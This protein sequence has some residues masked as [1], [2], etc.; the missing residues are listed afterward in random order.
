MVITVVI[1]YHHY[2]CLHHYYHRHQ[3]ESSEPYSYHTTIIIYPPSLP[4]LSLPQSSTLSLPLP[5]YHYDHLITVMIGMTISTISPR[6]TPSNTTQT[7]RL[8]IQVINLGYTLTPIGCIYVLRSHYA[9][10]PKYRTYTDLHLPNF[11]SSSEIGLAF[12]AKR[13]N[14][15]P[16]RGT[17]RAEALKP[18]T[19]MTESKRDRLR[20]R[21][22]KWRFWMRSGET[23]NLKAVCNGWF[24]TMSFDANMQQCNIN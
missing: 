1:R 18:R 21:L 2:T 16:R 11:P 7:I 6:L 14:P 19:P 23:I 13:L 9:I 5:L 22:F 15:W 3:Y 12:S 17:E 20:N 10:I 8:P 24:T 4:S